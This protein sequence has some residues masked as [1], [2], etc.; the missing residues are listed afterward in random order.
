MA[1]KVQE[2]GDGCA[3]RAYLPVPPRAGR[4]LALQLVRPKP[5]VTLLTPDAG[6]VDIQPFRE[7]GSGRQVPPL[8]HTVL[9]RIG[10]GDSGGV[11]G[12]HETAAAV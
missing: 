6:P 12:E 9:L 7:R 10:P 2:K 4:R 5:A 1:R 11:D 3:A 8:I